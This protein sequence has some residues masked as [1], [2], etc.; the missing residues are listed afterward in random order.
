MKPYNFAKRV[1][2][3]LALG[4]GAGASAQTVSVADK[5]RQEAEAEVATAYTV[6]FDTSGSM[7][8]PRIAQ[9]KQA[10]LWWLGSVQSGNVWSVLR[11]ENGR[12]LVVVPFKPSGQSEVAAAIERFVADGN[13]PI[14]ATLTV[15]RRQISERQK[16]K[17]YERHVILLFTDGDETQD[18][19]RNGA[20]VRK[21]LELRAENIEVIGIGYAGAGDYME[22][23]ASRYFSAADQNGLKTGLAQVEVEVDPMAPVNVTPE[24]LK[25]LAEPTAKANAKQT[26]VGAPRPDLATALA[27]ADA[28]MPAA[29]TPTPAPGRTS[30]PVRTMFLGALIVTVVI[31]VMKKVMR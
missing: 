4:G 17:P 9:A 8:G 10:F 21:I 7:K 2:F 27:A 28:A 23:A 25:K 14:V 22:R 16:L 5:F 20:V 31:M 13:T 24:E 19:G 3:A 30:S 26:G 11:F 18:T 1:L 12:G 29:A 6:V 15:A